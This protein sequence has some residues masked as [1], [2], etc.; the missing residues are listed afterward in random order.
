ML[1][2]LVWQRKVVSESFAVRVTQLCWVRAKLL[3]TEEKK[4]NGSGQREQEAMVA[5]RSSENSLNHW[6]S[7]GVDFLRGQRRPHPNTQ[8]QSVNLDKLSR[9]RVVA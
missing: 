4:R 5:Q 3:Q 8:P 2:P 7:T 9:A 6:E 1:Q